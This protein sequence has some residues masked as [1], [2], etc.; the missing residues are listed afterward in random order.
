MSDAIDIEA[1]TQ[2]QQKTWSEG[3]FAMVAGLV[4]MVAEELAESLEIMPGE[5]VLDV[6]CGSGNGALA[7]ARRS[8]GNT[9]GVD[10]VPAL[11]E[12]GRERAAAERLEVE[13][14]EGDAAELPFEDA[15][16]RRRRSRSSARCSRPT[17]RR[18]RPSCC[19]SASRAGGSGWPTGCRT[20]AS[21]A[22]S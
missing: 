12:R 6:A 3:D 22:S 15:E 13:F 1:L 18:R 10:F 11:L 4:M 20:G 7:A 2:A 19:A 14:V 9:V 17:R 8:W 16:L 21:A 5:R